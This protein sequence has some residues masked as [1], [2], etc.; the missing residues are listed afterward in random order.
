M[1]NG[2]TNFE[3]WLFMLYFEEDLYEHLREKQEY[4]K[5]EITFATVY[6]TVGAILDELSNSIDKVEY[7]YAFLKDIVDASL[8]SIN[9]KE[10]ADH[11]IRELNDEN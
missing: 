6:E 5:E 8:S 10:V 7:G 2:Y 3:T 9:V 4:E 1:Y 11:L